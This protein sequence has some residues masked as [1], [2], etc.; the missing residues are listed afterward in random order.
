MYSSRP[1]RSSKYE[2]ARDARGRWATRP[3]ADRPRCWCWLLTAIVAR[4]RRKKSP[5]A[6]TGRARAFRLCARYSRAE[7]I[8]H[9]HDR[10]LLASAVRRLARRSSPR[11]RQGKLRRFMPACLPPDA[12]GPK[13][14]WRTRD[15][16]P[17]RCRC[18]SV[19]AASYLAGCFSVSGDHHG[20]H[21]RMSAFSQRQGN[22]QSPPP[23]VLGNAFQKSCSK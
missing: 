20:S 2:L 22:E 5:S 8:A 12:H 6:A 11:R 4:T 13:S 16:A 7:S 9:N 23:A 15:C 14:S 1:E 17:G 18:C 3:Q 21:E 10:P 19:T